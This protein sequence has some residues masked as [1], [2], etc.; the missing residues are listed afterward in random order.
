MERKTGQPEV[1]ERVEV[2]RAERTTVLF[3]Y[4]A[5][6]FDGLCIVCIVFFPPLLLAYSLYIPFLYFSK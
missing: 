2:G 1:G 4:G 5:I 6:I 3:F